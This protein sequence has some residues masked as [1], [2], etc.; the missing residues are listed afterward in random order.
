MRREAI[1]TTAPYLCF[2]LLLILAEVLIRALRIPNYLLPP[3]SVIIAEGARNIPLL[4]RHLAI[5]FLEAVL[6][7]IVGNVC[8]I[9]FGFI[10]SQWRLARQGFYP[11]VVAFQAV[12]IVAVAPFVN[13][14]FGPGLV[15][16]VVMAALICYFPAAVISTDGFSKVNRDAL[17]LLRSLGATKQRIFRVLSLP[18]A[19][20]AIV[21]AL[22][23]SATLCMVG[24]V[25]AE[26]SG[27]DKGAGYL[28]LRA[29]YEFR[30]PMLFAVLAVTSG[31]TFGLFKCVQ[32]LGGYYARRY[33][34]SYA[35]PDER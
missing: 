22:Q 19:I 26:L 13:I 15:G 17:A 7:F 28:I 35:I 9:L 11:I 14:W 8:A 24:A 27:S 5:T 18:S 33:T 31:A 3:P 1:R 16:K 20:P 4:M 34:F 12:P 23:V 32:L 25:V 21:S 6:G 30:T 29:S 2:M 10:F